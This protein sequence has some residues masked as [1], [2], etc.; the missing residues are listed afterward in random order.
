[1]I[2]AGFWVPWQESF[3]KHFRKVADFEV[4]QLVIEL[5]VCFFDGSGSQKAAC[6]YCKTYSY[7]VL[8]YYDEGIRIHREALLYDVFQLSIDKM[9]FLQDFY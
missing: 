2:F 1:M 7:M 8:P 6:H 4:T 5:Q 3:L 9:I